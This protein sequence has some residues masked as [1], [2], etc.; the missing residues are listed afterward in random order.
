[1]F[2]DTFA[3]PPPI[4]RPARR[5]TRL[6]G[7]A[8]T[9]RLRGWLHLVALV[10]APPAGL[11]LVAHAASTGATWSAAVYA[12]TLVGLYAVS[13]AYHVPNW[14][15]ATRAAFRLADR[16]TIYAFIAGC[17]T[18]FCFVVIG[19]PLGSVIAALA[20]AVACA[21]VLLTMTRLERARVLCGLLYIAQGWLA[22]AALPVIVS[23]L[24]PA[25]LVLLLAGGLLF[26][27]GAAVLAGRRP[28]P[29]PGWFGY[30]EVWHAMVVLGT[31][32]H[33]ALLW[34]LL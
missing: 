10:T 12:V 7:D 28:D 9:D 22:V 17:Y 14:R 16:S 30:H 20:W 21:G 23:R 13:V 34:Q 15:P 24:A 5:A 31:V 26:T 11:A 19:G 27:L 33:F 32:L 4:V 8:S 25:Q 18:P 3:T 1:M 2:R 29:L 6:S